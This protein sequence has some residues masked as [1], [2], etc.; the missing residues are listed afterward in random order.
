MAPFLAVLQPCLGEGEPLLASHHTLLHGLS[1]GSAHLDLQASLCTGGAHLLLCRVDCY[2][3]CPRCL[4]VQGQLPGGCWL[5]NGLAF[6]F[7][8]QPAFLEIFVRWRLRQQDLSCRGGGRDLEG[9]RGIFF[10]QEKDRMFL[11]CQSLR[12]LDCVRDFQTGRIRNEWAAPASLTCCFTPAAG[13]SLS[14][15]PSVDFRR[16]M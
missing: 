6:V 12:G 16:R 1:T 7:S 11:A 13:V 3:V 14:H 9:E 8:K 10:W 15:L 4:W 5:C 2:Q